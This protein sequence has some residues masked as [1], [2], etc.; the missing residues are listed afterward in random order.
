[1]HA[2]RLAA[3]VVLLGGC[4]RGCLMTWLTQ[5]GGGAPGGTG[6]AAPKGMDLAG[7]D[8]SD[9]LLRCVDGRVE[10]SRIAH[11]P[12]PCGLGGVERPSACIC[13]WDTVARCACAADGLEV[14]AAPTD[15]GIEQLCKAHGPVARPVLPEDSVTVDVCAQSGVSCVDGAI[16]ICPA[17]GQPSRPVAVCTWGCQTSISLVDDATEPPGEPRDPDGVLS[18]LCRR[19]DAERR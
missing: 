3:F 17:S 15:A 4:E 8:C 16:R 2:A 14:V 18:I 19:G 5:N 9:G 11:L 12:S 6:G 10:A 7:T 1:M 13:P